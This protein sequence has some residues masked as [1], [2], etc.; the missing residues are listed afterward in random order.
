MI[1]AIIKNSAESFF[2]GANGIVHGRRDACTSDASDTWRTSFESTLDNRSKPAVE[3]TMQMHS[4]NDKAYR[5]TGTSSG[6]EAIMGKVM[7]CMEERELSDYLREEE[8][9]SD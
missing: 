3:L 2:A 4:Y 5:P 6:D 1:I 9:R 8:G 7:G